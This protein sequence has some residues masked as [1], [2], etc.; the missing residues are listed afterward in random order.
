MVTHITMHIQHHTSSNMN[1]RLP[2]AQG[3]DSSQADAVS[4]TLIQEVW[5]VVDQNYLDARNTGFDAGKVRD[6]PRNLK[7]ENPTF[8]A[9]NGSCCIRDYNSVS[10]CAVGWAERRCTEQVL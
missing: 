9:L 8:E 6:L 2:P 7:Q 5:E 1:V 3:E 10:L 4:H